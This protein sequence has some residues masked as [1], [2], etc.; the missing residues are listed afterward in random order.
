[1]HGLFILGFPK[2]TRFLAHHDAILTKF[3][4]KLKRHFDQCNL[5]SILYSLKWFF[6]VFVE[7]VSLSSLKKTPPKNDTIISQIP[8]SLCLRVWD[9]YLHE[10]ERVATAMAYTVLKL[11]KNKLLKLK[12]MDS[13]VHYLQVKLVKD[14]GYD[15]DFV[16]KT[17]EQCAEELRK[18]KMELPPTPQ[19][20]EFPQK[21][22]GVFVEPTP[23]EKVGHRKTDFSEIEKE[24]TENV[25]KS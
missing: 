8:F 6:V 11:H 16:I 12:D 20:I 4:P 13:I 3:L 17:Y 2:L 19:D 1:M 21:P 15:D 25:I 7:R 23:E 24:V 22:F 10:G 5:D 9:I 18:A 14:F